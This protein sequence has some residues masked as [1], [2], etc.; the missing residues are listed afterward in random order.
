MSGLDQLSAA[1][2]T[3]TI[4]RR[5]PTI[6]YFIAAD[7]ASFGIFFAV[8]MVD[9]VQRADL[10]NQSARQL[11][12]GLGLLNTLVLIT[13]GWTMALAVQAV[14]RGESR[15]ARTL[16]LTSALVGSGFLVVKAIEWGTEIAG[17]VTPVTNDFFT[18]YFVLTGV[19]F[20]H[21]LIGMVVLIV[22]AAMAR[23]PRVRGDAFV[24]WVES[25]GIYWHMVDLLWIFLFPMIYLIGVR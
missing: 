15:K 20:F 25:G 18:Y 10:F 1:T 7:C 5:L 19:H 11:D 23:G 16:L 2:G 22:L 13:S 17:G 9:R 24:R 4:A 3:R 14:R 21:Y 6:W 12:V 8:F